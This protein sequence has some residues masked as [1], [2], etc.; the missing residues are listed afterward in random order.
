MEFLA[1]LHHKVIHFPIAFLMVYPLIEILALTTG[2]D[3]FVKSA[4]V[5]LL[6]GTLGSLA[7]VFTGNQAFTFIKEWQNDSLQVFDSHQTFA[8]IS[9]WY[10]TGL[11]I[12]RTYL[13]IKKKLNKKILIVFVI[14]SLIGAYL[15]FQT[16]N[17]GGELAKERFRISAIN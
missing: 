6:I 5:F 13:S 8:S 16:A 4:G 12:L 10:F 11:L 7:A 1:N 17:Y 15:I 2:K 9:V 3:F 14:L